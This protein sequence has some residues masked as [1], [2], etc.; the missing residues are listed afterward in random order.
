MLTPCEVAVKSVIP[1]IRAYVAKELTRTHKMKQTDIANMLGITQTAISKYI[2]HVRG[3]AITI[4][5][6]EEIQNMMDDI[7]LRIANEK[8]TGPQLTLEFCEVCRVVRL[9]GLMCKLCKLSDQTL[10]IAMCNV[11]KKG[12]TC[13]S[14]I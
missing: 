13:S 14:Q 3:R 4:D 9:N 10:D 12:Q 7:A 8:I 5:Q 1:A 11:C 6:T 2:R